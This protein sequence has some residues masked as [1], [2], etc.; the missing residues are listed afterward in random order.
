MQLNTQFAAEQKFRKSML[1]KVL[2]A[3]RFL[4]R[5]GLL[6]RGYCEDVEYFEGNLYQLLLLQSK[7]LPRM[8]QWLHQK[9]Y[10]S[11][12]IINEIINGSNNT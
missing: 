4:G 3:V 10:I 7:E 8:R 6:L 9:E 2:E 12:V 11:P 5:Q 1:L